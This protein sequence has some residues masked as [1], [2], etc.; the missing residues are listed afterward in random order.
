MIA[1]YCVTKVLFQSIASKVGC[2]KC[3]KASQTGP[4]RVCSSAADMKEQNIISLAV[5]RIEHDR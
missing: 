3:G 5:L 1:C 2:G 4:R